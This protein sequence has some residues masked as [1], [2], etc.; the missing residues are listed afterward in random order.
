MEIVRGI[1]RIESVLG[2]RPFSQYLLWGERALLVDTGIVSTPDEVIL[3]FFATIGLDPVDL[4]YVLISHADVDHFG[5]NAA[6]RAAAPAAVFCAHEQDAGWI[7]DRERILR[8]RYGWY[9]AHG[10]AA[11]YDAAS[12]AWLRDAMGEEVPV[13][14]RLRGG[15]VFALGPG[16]TVEVLYL[17]GHSQGHVGLWEPESRTAIVIDAV[18]GRGLYDLDGTVIHPPPYTHAAAYEETIA[19]LQALQPNLLLTA[20]YAPMAGAD[21]ER[22]LDESA[23][24]VKRARA[25]VAERVEQEGEVTL[26]GLLAALD[27]VLGP[28]ASMPNEL[29]GPI[30][31]HLRELTGRGIVVEVEGADPPV[32]RKVGT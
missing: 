25:A 10:P 15:E 6:I 26:A 4:D 30:W 19:N 16:L 12:K 24:F 32:W 22:F 9:A 21:V 11:D 1:H 8:E 29:G 23:A 20:H 3:P 28:F 5:G 14:L 7:E 17:P 31:S 18:L 27:P 2:P 13:T